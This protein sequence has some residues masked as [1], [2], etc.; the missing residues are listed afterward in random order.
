MKRH[1]IS[2]GAKQMAN[3]RSGPDRAQL[4]DKEY[5]KIMKEQFLLGQEIAASGG[6]KDL[7]NMK[8]TPYNTKKKK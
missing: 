4:S 2:I 5:D 6:P 7:F 3:N 8:D 1:S